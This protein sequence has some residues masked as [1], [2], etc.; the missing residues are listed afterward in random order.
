[1]LNKYQFLSLCHTPGLKNSYN[2]LH[3][4]EPGIIKNFF[5]TYP[6]HIN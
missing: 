6:D 2:T 5:A 4:P 3:H 1:M